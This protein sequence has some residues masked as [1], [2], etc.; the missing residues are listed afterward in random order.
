LIFGSLSIQARIF[1]ASM[2]I[3]EEYPPQ[4]NGV[5]FIEE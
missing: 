2:N 5:Y 1:I 3:M 4:N